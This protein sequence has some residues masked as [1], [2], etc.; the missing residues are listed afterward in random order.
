[1]QAIPIPT[2]PEEAA[3]TC[4]TLCA[5][6]EE[7]QF[8]VNAV[9]GL[10]LLEHDIH[11]FMAQAG[12]DLPTDPKLPSQEVRELRVKLI[13]EELAELCGAFKVDLHLDTTTSTLNVN[14]RPTGD[15]QLDLLPKPA[16]RVNPLIDAYD[17]VLD[18]LVVVVGTGLAMGTRLHPGWVEVHRTNMAKFAPGGYRRADGKWIKPEDWQP[19]DLETAVY[20]A[21]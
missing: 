15:A 20:G 3:K 18:L 4:H 21:N 7:T 1:M 12:Q 14:A 2:T 13:A 19:P 16:T 10:N 8:A 5:T 17:A 6:L 11:Q 9:S